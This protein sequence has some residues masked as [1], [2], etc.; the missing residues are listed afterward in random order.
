M[1]I[2]SFWYCVF[3]F[4]FDSRG[5]ILVFS[6][7]AVRTLYQSWVCNFCAS[8]LSDVCN[9]VVS[10]HHRYT[11]AYTIVVLP[12]LSVRHHILRVNPC[13]AAIVARQHGCRLA[14]VVCM[15]P[16]FTRHVHRS[17]L[18]WYFTARV[19]WPGSFPVVGATVSVHV[20]FV[21]R[22]IGPLEE[23]RRYRWIGIQVGNFCTPIN[24]VFIF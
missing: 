12:L 20:F 17:A 6:P 15:S 3:F 13:R 24:F 4:F 1:S 19:D 8:V 18:C 16:W 7:S 21:Q 14:V 23:T 10:S 2:A 9:G 22:L 11:Y 5:N